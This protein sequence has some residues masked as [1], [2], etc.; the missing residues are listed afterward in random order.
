VLRSR[1]GLIDSSAA[2]TLSIQKF[3]AS[4]G[5]VNSGSSVTLSWEV[6]GAEQVAIQDRERAAAWHALVPGVRVRNLHADRR[7]G[8]TARLERL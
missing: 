2:P 7:A 1:A 6:E 8:R 4:P 5:E 3:D